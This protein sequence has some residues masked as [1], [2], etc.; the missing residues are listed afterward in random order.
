MLWIQCKSRAPLAHS[1]V[2]NWLTLL[3][4]K[5]ETF[6]WI[7]SDPKITYYKVCRTRNNHWGAVGMRESTVCIA[8]IHFRKYKLPL[9]WPLH[10]TISQQAMF[11][12]SLAAKRARQLRDRCFSVPPAAMLHWVAVRARDGYSQT[13]EGFQW[14]LCTVALL[15]LAGFHKNYSAFGQVTNTFIFTASPASSSYTLK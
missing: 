2:L 15:R 14:S 13:E 8:Y 12:K 10:N 5:Q 9:S 11:G 1:V 6:F 3:P 4:T 7:I